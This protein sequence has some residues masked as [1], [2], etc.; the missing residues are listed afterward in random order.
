MIKH[1]LATENTCCGRTWSSAGAHR[2]SNT[3]GSNHMIA[4]TRSRASV[5]VA[6]SHPLNGPKTSCNRHAPTW[7]CETGNQSHT[8]RK[9][10]R[11]SEEGGE[12]LKKGRDSQGQ[13]ERERLEEEARQRNPAVKLDAN[14]RVAAT[15]R[16]GSIPWEE[17]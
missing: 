2:T 7:G 15:K 13:R 1:V 11:N 10:E 16:C 9:R 17:G 8:N 12:F 14:A 5:R 3:K 6:T 4:D